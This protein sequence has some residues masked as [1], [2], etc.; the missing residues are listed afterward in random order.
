[1]NYKNRYQIKYPFKGKVFYA[2]DISKVIPLCAKDFKEKNDLEEG[3]F[4]IVD[5]DNNEEYKF[6]QENGRIRKVK[7]IKIMDQQGGFFDWFGSE[8]EE[9]IKPMKI[10]V[11][12]SPGDENNYKGEKDKDK[13]KNKDKNK[14]KKDDE[15]KKVEIELDSDDIKLEDEP[16]VEVNMEPQSLIDKRF[17]MLL[18]EIK[19]VDTKLEN[20][21]QQLTPT[22][23][24]QTELDRIDAER[25][26][27]LK[28]MKQ[29]K[30]E[31]YTKHQKPDPVIR[32]MNPERVYLA[33]QKKLEA[34][35]SL[36]DDTLWWS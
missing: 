21:K 17:A 27:I 16:L 36:Y 3:I 11:S 33:N 22:P 30:P 31:S 9:K 35:N 14:D 34:T 29:A 15:T 26:K 12:I 10:E 6:K 8:E 32:S 19:K 13:D 24:E 18:D 5:L 2:K 28:E 4:S 25:E 1:M 7:E 20:L 23:P